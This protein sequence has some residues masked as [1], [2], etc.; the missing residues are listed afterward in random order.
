MEWEREKEWEREMERESERE[1]KMEKAKE[2]KK[3][4]EQERE[5]EREKE[6]EK[7]WVVWKR[8]KCLLSFSFPLFDSGVSSQID[9]GTGCHNR[10]FEYP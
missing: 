6:K 8:E 9:E 1:L 5:R 3:K 7:E 2:M 10:G 4:T